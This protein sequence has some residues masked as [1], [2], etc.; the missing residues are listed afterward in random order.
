MLLSVH[1]KG[2]LCLRTRNRPA[3]R[4]GPGRREPGALQEAL[5]HQGAN[6]DASPV[7]SLSAL[8]GDVRAGMSQASASRGDKQTC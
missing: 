2:R 4:Q 5:Q 7:S 8:V 6:A 1:P 3:K